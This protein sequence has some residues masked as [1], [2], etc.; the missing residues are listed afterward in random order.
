MKA[1]ERNSRSRGTT[2]KGKNLA[3]KSRNP[4]LPK[5]ASVRPAPMAALRTSRTPVEKERPSPDAYASSKEKL[6]ISKI[7]T[8]KKEK[9]DLYLAFK[10]R[11]QALQSQLDKSVRESQSLKSILK[12]LLPLVRN[13]LEIGVRAQLQRL[14]DRDTSRPV[15][16]S[17][18]ATQ[19][20]LVVP[21]ICEA[22][23]STNKESTAAQSLGDSALS[24]SESCGK[25]SRHKG[26]LPCAGRTELDEYSSGAVE[27]LR[28]ENECYRRYIH[29]MLGRSKGARES[30]S[31]AAEAGEAGAGGGSVQPAA[32]VLPTFIKSM[33]IS[34]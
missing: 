14:L 17:D 33:Y 25:H 3:I 16:I 28:D 6:L 26:R 2:P 8:L 13:N 12:Q 32:H 10:R 30:K 18:A 23:N 20:S 31:A 19:C 1:S 21:M 27:R 34:P 7:I 11:E 15:A 5:S 4:S 22:G 29:Y 9:N 24:N